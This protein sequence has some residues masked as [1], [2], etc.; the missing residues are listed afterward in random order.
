MANYAIYLAALVPGVTKLLLEGKV[1]F[2]RDSPDQRFRSSLLAFLQRLPHNDTLKAHEATLMSTALALL[3]IENEENALLCIKIIIDGFRSHKE[4]TE[5]HVQPFLDLV[6]KMYSNTKSV[7]ENEFGSGKATPILQPQS[8][9]PAAVATAQGATS[10]AGAAT[11]ATGTAAAATPTPTPTMMLHAL[12]SPRVLTECP[13]A[14]VL[15]FQSFKS[16]MQSAMKDFYPLVMESI[17][18]QP[19]PQKQAY[20]EAKAKG[21]IFTGVADGIKNREMYAEVIKSQVKTMA[22]LAYVLRGSA[23]NVRNWLDVFP[24]AC[25]RLLRDCPPED[26]ATRKELLIAT[27]HMLTSD[28]RTAFIP[29]IDMLLN[30][31]V[32]VGSGVTSREALRPLA[33]STLADLIHHTRN[34]LSQPQL[35]RVVSVY[36]C[37]TH[38]ATYPITIQTMCTKLVQTSIETICKQGQK[39]EAI[40]LLEGILLTVVEKLKSLSK[41]YDRMKRAESST[42]D[43]ADRKGYDEHDWRAIERAMPILSVAFA[44]DSF[45]VFV[46]DAKN[47]LRTLLS[48]LKTLFQNLRA[49]DVPPTDGLVLGEL[50]TFG[51]SCLRIYDTSRDP[52]EEKEAMDVLS[53]LIAAFDSH[54]FSEVWTNGLEFYTAQVLEHG[55][56]IAILQNMLISIDVSHQTV[57]ILLRYLMARL[58]SIGQ[59]SRAESSLTLKLFKLSFMAVN[60]FIDANEPVL[61]PHL[62]KLIVNSFSYAAKSPDPLIYYQILRALFRSIGGGRFE[63]LYK[64]VLPILEEMLETL[65]YLLLHA[66]KGRRDLFVELCLTVP[67]RLTNLLPHLGYLMKPLVHALNA[68]PDLVSQGL[69]TLEL[70]IDNLTSEFLDP[71]M[72]PVLREL[73]T[74]LYSLLKPMPFNHNHSHSAVKIL[75]KLGGRNRRFQHPPY[76]LEWK[77]QAQ[78]LRHALSIEN[79]DQSIDVYDWLELACDHSRDSD[80]TTRK[81]AI[82]LLKECTKLFLTDAYKTRDQEAIL[83]RALLGL[84]EAAID[85]EKDNFI[86]HI[87][88]FG[89]E[90]MSRELADKTVKRH[91]LL[92]TRLTLLGSTFVNALSQAVASQAPNTRDILE[93]V[94]KDFFAQK[95]EIDATDDLQGKDA[96]LVF[97]QTLF[98]KFHSLCFEEDW[99]RKRSGCLGL[100]LLWEH[101]QATENASRQLEYLRAIFFVIRDA[102]KDA[103]RNLQDVLQ[104][105]KTVVKASADRV[106]KVVDILVLELP[107]QKAAVR[108][109]AKEC[110]ELLAEQQSVSVHDLIG[111]TAKERLL[112]PRSTIFNKP[113]RALPFVMQIG[114]IDAITYLLNVR[115]TLPAFNEEMMRLLQ[116]TIALADADDA[117]LIGRVTHHALEVS[118]RNL[119]V[120]CLELLC[121]ANSAGDLGLLRTRVTQVYFKYMYSPHAEIVEVAHKGL[122]SVLQ[123]QVKLPKDILQTGLRPILVNLADARRLSVSGLEGLARFLELLTNYFKVEIGIKLLDHFRS[124]SDPNMLAAAAVKPYEDNSDI[125]RMVRLVNVFRL[126]PPTANM[127]LK[128]LTTLVADAETK[129]HQSRP[130]P[131][132]E[133]LALYFEKYPTDAA[134]F[135]LDSLSNDAVVRTYL[136]VIESGKAPALVVELTAQSQKICTA[137]FHSGPVLNG[138]RIIQKLKLSL[139]DHVNVLE[140]LVAVWR[141]RA[142]GDVYD[143]VP[144]AILEIFMGYLEKNQD[145]PL[146]FHVV[147]AYE[148]KSALDR[149][150]IADFLYRTV[151]ATDNSTFQSDV[152]AHFLGL[153]GDADVSATFKTNAFRMVINPMLWMHHSRKGS[154]LMTKATGLKIAELI[155]R[156][157]L[158]DHKTKTIEDSLVIEILHMSVIL[159]QY[160]YDTVGD[161]RKDIIKVAWE[162]IRSSDATVKH[163]SYLLAARF[164]VAY[165]SPA[166]IVRTTWNGLLKVKETEGRALY[167]K[168]INILASSLPLRD[169][170]PRPGL[171]SNWALTTKKVLMEEGHTTPQLMSICELIVG[172]PDL[173]YDTREMFV[174]LMANSLTKLG[175]TPAATADMKKLTIDIV[176]LIFR[177]ERRRITGTPSGTVEDDGPAAKK[178]KLATG[179]AATP[180][181][182]G[183]ASPATGGWQLPVHVRELIT[184]YLVRLVSSSNESILKGGLTSRALNLLREILGPE[185]LPGVTAKLNFFQRTMGQDVKDETL[186]Q[187]S[188]SAEVIAIVAAN[189]DDA[190]MLNYLPTLTKLLENAVLS[191]YTNLHDILR[192][193]MERLFKCGQGDAGATLQQWV[194][195]VIDNLNKPD[196]PVSAKDHLHGPLFVISC[197]VK[198]RPEKAETITP[199]LIKIASKLIRE[200]TNTGGSPPLPPPLAENAHRLIITV[201]DI[202]QTLL[203]GMKEQRRH[204]L[205]AVYHLIEH[206]PT[207]SMCRYIMN[208]LR[209]WILV[210]KDGIP[211]FKEKAGLLNKM[212][213]FE[214]RKDEAL[215]NDYLRF[216]L[217]IFQDPDLQ[218]TDLTSRLENSFLLGTRSKDPVLRSQFIDMLDASLPRD[219][220]GRLQYLLSTQ[221]WDFLA[222]GYWMP[223]AT[224]LLYGCLEPNQARPAMIRN[225]RRLVHADPARTHTIWVT[226]FEACWKALAR[227]QQI[228]IER[229]LTGLLVKEHHIEQNALRPNVIQTLLAGALAC[230]RNFLLPAYV[231]KYL[232]KTYGAWHTGLEILTRNLENYDDSHQLQENCADALGELYAELAEDDLFYGLWRRRCVH[233]ETNAALALEQN[234]LWSRA[235][236]V[237]EI[238]QSRA[239][240]GVI[241]YTENEY[242]LWQDHWIL[243]AQK[244]Q[245]WDI[246][247]DLARHEGNHDLLLECAWRLSDWGSN[248]R[249]MIERSLEAVADVA[250]PR[251][252]VFEAYTALIKAHTGQDQPADFLRVLDEAIQLSIRKWVSLPSQ[253]SA[254]HTPLLQLFQQYVELQEAAGVFESLSLTNPMNLEARVTQ[255]L[256]PIFQTWRERLP[257]FWDDISVW[258][259]L[260][261]WRQHVFAAVT[262]VYVPL[263]PPNETATYG[264]RGYHETAWTINR[265]GHVARKHQLSDVCTS[266][267]SKIYNLPNIEISEAFLKLREQAMCFYQ[268]PEKYAEG[269]D[270][271][272]TTNL[273]YFAPAQKAEFLTLKGMFIAKLGQNEDA[274]LAFAQAVQMD[275]SLPKAWAEWGKYNDRLFRMTPP[276]PEP[277]VNEVAYHAKRIG[278]AGNAVS[279]YLQAA[280]LYKSAKARKLLIRV[281]WLLGL[282][283]SSGAI[284]R[285]F[286]TYQGD[287]AVWYWITLIPQLLQSLI[288]REARH[289]R[290]ILMKIA[291][292]FPQALYYQLRTAREENFTLLRQQQH[293]AQQRRYLQERER[294]RLAALA[295]SANTGEGSST[296]SNGAE[297]AA[298]AAST[299]SSQPPATPVAAATAPLPASTP[300]TAST[301]SAA[302]AAEDKPK[303]TSAPPVSSA[304]STTPIQASAP[305]PATATTQPPVPP[306]P[307]IKV[308]AVDGDRPPNGAPE[309]QANGQAGQQQ[310]EAS[311]G[312]RAAGAPPAPTAPGTLGAPDASGAPGAANGAP[313]GPPGP[314]ANVSRQPHELIDEVLNILKTAFPLLALSMEKMVDCILSR[315]APTTEEMVYRFLSALLNDALAQWSSK[316]RLPNDNDILPMHTREKIKQYSQHPALRPDMKKVFHE[317]FLA[318]PCSMRAYITKLQ[319][320]HG[321]YERF[322]DARP[323]TEP[324]DQGESLM[325]DYHHTKFDEVE[326][327]GQYMEH[328]DSNNDFIKIAR[329]A[330]TVDVARGVGVCYRR[331]TIIGSSGSRHGFQVQAPSGRH[332]RREERLL[333]LFK[334]MNSVLQRRKESRKRH[335]GIHLPSVIPLAP[336][337]RLMVHDSSYSSMQDVFDEHCKTIGITRDKP[338]LEFIDKFRQL[339]F[340][341]ER[342]DEDVETVEYKV[343]RME[344]VEEMATKYVPETVLSDYMISSMADP[345]SLWLMRKHFALQ[346]AASMYVSYVACLNN[347]TPGRFHFSHKTGLM[348]MSEILPAFEPHAAFHRNPEKVPFRLTPNMQHFITPTGVEGLLTSGVM[349]IARSLS[350]PE[351]DLESSLTLFIRDEVSLWHAMHNT[352]ANDRPNDVYQN[353]DGWVRRTAELAYT[354]ENP[355]KVSRR[356]GPSHER[357]ANNSILQTDMT[358]INA[359]IIGLIARATNTQFLAQTNEAFLPYF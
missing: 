53:G 273:M 86:A 354:G 298:A 303:E 231:V 281:L 44:N 20:A 102:P 264:Y 215:M 334:I 190:W 64:E 294:R 49:M 3:K 11:P 310:A 320:W 19:E 36:S 268:K 283:D 140:A 331:I 237:Y 246:L 199:I 291:K 234:G 197:Y 192:P 17:R 116:E 118:L 265:F 238:G 163:M 63:A 325:T 263:I 39:D 191:E 359:V 57:A 21:E 304:A 35:A 344:L 83:L 159:V 307:I 54:I 120:A 126:L 350:L 333:P 259:D 5:Q 252:K 70:C 32:L 179:A 217:D 34:E 72:A 65:N 292:S 226:A 94:L 136:H 130:G 66:E 139:V 127:F 14:V 228:S 93:A 23:E 18:I 125:A 74:A 342:P 58:E 339:Y 222:N 329:F 299:A 131:F 143:R 182:P 29:Y 149:N 345:S 123:V 233:D 76:L 347:R 295:A 129:L 355:D 115:P 254:A 15:I 73:M 60:T 178:Q 144:T 41:A 249:E 26:V 262:K 51:I 311:N 101:S 271:I 201:L 319:E 85:D 212:M 338:I 124:L 206:C 302:P 152:F 357:S 42:G 223:L 68:G 200:L 114:N 122:K 343:T 30:E 204:F 137:C 180:P 224:D 207:I 205:S 185:G 43:E 293:Q 151:A 113:L 213:S 276:R 24:E 245:Q 253:Q 313:Q 28:F 335:L 38:D 111:A 181:P 296:G 165:D 284:S 322:L 300:A 309:Q 308:E 2:V 256:K 8:Q 232:S 324:L 172:Q 198:A 47:I 274:N 154:S 286:E 306:Q 109:A 153:Y 218:R 103:P 145:V 208:M 147:E 174:S 37:L 229:W 89:H 241:P 341:T 317:T 321:E 330:P 104:L 96:A 95:A 148:I 216:I 275:L 90:V 45:E 146:L 162:C 221:G 220:L 92:S 117:S 132:T 77:P 6:K 305:A 351:Y 356:L 164:F 31:K 209:E 9:P 277:G 105:L 187:V 108:K 318:R 314:P 193:I 173:F 40:K 138:I 67:V 56:H 175:F 282:D 55:H 270:S 4:Q 219:V 323:R 81:D 251:R 316:V 235:Q 269:L 289:A 80:A 194:D 135:L 121:A 243:A 100:E 133:N 167:R 177:W 141:T 52:R 110:I 59:Q 128:D 247:T 250:T 84:F 169:P 61:V 340:P 214:L 258:S 184:S 75:G 158:N 315:A 87:R 202:C 107:S 267:L 12:H 336:T 266:A 255:D 16:I 328:V 161:V 188:N 279:C 349:A 196:K 211:S 78:Q 260:L 7:I 272:S 225:V 285:S 242:N 71:T 230:G 195:N 358:P 248:D 280:G 346:T 25:V 352:K 88:D 99:E 106:K 170:P 112:D 337:V 332:C 240:S 156:P 160:C 239:R 50:F 79:A 288:H 297:G 189:K 119:R 244:L 278:F 203:E 1:T 257:N 348:F 261:A 142:R 183:S 97:L 46:R 176:E 48:T 227:P 98:L 290:G 353:V 91:G 22:F 287:M 27:R 10:A 155:W 326:V 186:V 69:R 312:A 236:E 171:P 301:T 62:S 210:R 150:D 82:D 134:N 166:Q 168:A 13:I 327:P 33:Y 157:L